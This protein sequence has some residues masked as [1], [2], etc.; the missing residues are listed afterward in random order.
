MKVLCSSVMGLCEGVKRALYLVQ[1]AQKENKKPIHLLG[2]L[3]HNRSL[4]Q[5]LKEQGIFVHDSLDLVSTIENISDGTVVFS[6]HGH[7]PELEKICQE[8]KLSF[9][10]ATCP[11]VKKNMEKIKED[12]KKKIPVFYIGVANHPETNAAISLSKDIHFLSYPNPKYPKIFLRN[13]HV[14]YQTTLSKDVLE[15]IKKEMIK[16]YSDPIFVDDICHATNLRQKALDEVPDSTDAIF[17]IGDDISSNSK[18]LYELAKAHYPNKKVFFVSCL[19]DVE[20]IDFKGI[21]SAFVTAGASTPDFS[22]EP[23]LQ[24]LRSIK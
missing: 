8:K 9:L 18:R 5:Q 13:P 17:I 16:L 22:I 4:M 21:S 6:A 2:N 3:V 10:D 24:Y 19:H 23:I 7:N 12:L 11:H 20:Q 15:T 1:R 14:Y